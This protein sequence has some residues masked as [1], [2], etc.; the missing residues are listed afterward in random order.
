M[1][2]QAV[3]VDIAPCTVL[4]IISKQLQPNVNI[5][6]IHQHIRQ[7]LREDRSDAVFSLVDNHAQVAL[8]EMWRV[9]KLILCEYFSSYFNMTDTR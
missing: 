8:D 3:S 2:M 6:D 9:R 1:T 4:L 7:S 5:Q